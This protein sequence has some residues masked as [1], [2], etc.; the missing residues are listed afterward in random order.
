MQQ[1]HD[2]MPTRSDD[3]P[4]ILVMEDEVTVANGLK[5]ILTEE[6]YSVDLAMN[7]KSAL[8]SLWKSEFDLLLADLRLPDIDGMDVI[9]RAKIHQPDTEVVVITGY[10]T[11][12]SVIEAMKLG[13]HDFLPKPFTE[14]ELM[15]VVKGALDK[16]KTRHES[17]LQS[18]DSQAEACPDTLSSIEDSLQL[19][20]TLEKIKHDFSGQRENIIPMLQQVQHHIGYIPEIAM[21]E[22][23]Q[24][25]RTPPA[26]VFGVATFYEQFRL[27]PV[28]KHI[29]KVC[30]GTACHVKGADRIINE[31]SNR[32][33]LT[34]G[35]TS[36]DRSF[37]VE[38]VACFGSCAIAPVVV[39][40]DKVKG[41]MNPSKTC[42]EMHRVTS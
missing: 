8:S 17:K 20:D 23:A 9:K 35:Q 26:T 15:S 21:Q 27:H 2:T 34:P 28:G 5:M 4:H 16:R 36:R 10:S 42:K 39:V 41:R 14:D 29:V 37:T 3:W 19:G 7:G 24:H 11:I 22:I 12:P 30:R 25:T 31:I 13:A 40:D 32:F 6:G 18:Y 1:L 33:H 38:T